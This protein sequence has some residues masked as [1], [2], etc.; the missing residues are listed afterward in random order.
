MKIGWIFL[1]GVGCVSAQGY[2]DTYQKEIEKAFPGSVFKEIFWKKYVLNSQDE[3]YRRS[4]KNLCYK[5]LRYFLFL[6]GGDAII[7]KKGSEVYDLVHNELVSTI[8]KF[9]S[10]E[11]DKIVIIGHSL[12][13][14]IT[15]NFLWDV[16]NPNSQ[17]A[18][19]FAL[20][21]EVYAEYLKSSLL[22]VSTVACPAAIWS[23]KYKD[24]GECVDFEQFNG[25]K[26][27]YNI[28][29]KF[30]FIGWPMKTING[31]YD[32]QKKLIDVE[33]AY[34]KS[35]GKILPICHSQTWDSLPIIRKIIAN[36][37]P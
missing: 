12:G 14:I 17:G 20:S 35:I 7:Y 23:S 18:S 8:E 25:L 21:A 32:N 28:Y 30:D 3:I 2:S 11:V 36:I 22:H 4:A 33:M 29:S 5:F 31:T 24:G 16:L 37:K 6:Y 9:K 27:V 13:T 1:H 19:L 15:M 34:G 10:Q 26:N